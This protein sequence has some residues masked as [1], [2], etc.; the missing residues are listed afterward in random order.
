MASLSIA[1]KGY[2]GMAMTGAFA[3]PLFNFL[4][5]LSLS[6]ARLLIFDHEDKDSS[7]FS[8]TI[9]FNLFLEK[10]NVILISI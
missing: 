6:S 5:G 9:E 4:I 1:K 7:I 10:A 3:C 8:R 2:G